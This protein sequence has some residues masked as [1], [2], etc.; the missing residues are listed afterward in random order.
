MIREL[1]EK[2]KLNFQNRVDEDGEIDKF[3]ETNI[4]QLT[5]LLYEWKAE[6]I[7]SNEHGLLADIDEALTNQNSEIESGSTTVLILIYQNEVRFVGAWSEETY[8][9]SIPTQ[10]FKE[11]VIGWR[12]FLLTPPLNGTKMS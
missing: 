11:I 10:D 7:D 8:S 2:Y 9:I 1:I 6:D 5:N 4:D 3:P 12:D